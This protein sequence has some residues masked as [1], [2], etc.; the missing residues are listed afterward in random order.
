MR[1][2]KRLRLTWLTIASL[3]LS[4]GVLSACGADGASSTFNT[5]GPVAELQRNLLL[6]VVVIAAGVFVLVEG[7]IVFA[8]LRYR[9]KST[10]SEFPVQTH[11]NSRLELLW[12]AIP[13][14][15]I[16]IIAVPTVQAIW[17]L[18]GQD[19]DMQVDAIGHRWWFEFRY[20]GQGI[21]TANELVIPTGTNIRVNVS[22]ENVNHSFAVP[23]LFGTQDLIPNKNNYIVFSADKPGRYEGQ[24]REFCGL[25]HGKMQ[26]TVLAYPPDEFERWVNEWFTP[27][28]AEVNQMEGLLLFNQNCGTCHTNRLVGSDPYQAEIATQ[29]TRWAGWHGAGGEEGEPNIIPGP[30]LVNF[31]LRGTLAAQYDEPLSRESLL[32][33]IKDPS[34]FK[35]GTY[36]QRY[37]AVYGGGEA[38]LSDAEVQSITD[39]LLAL[40]PEGSTCANNCQAIINAEDEV[41]LR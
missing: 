17:T 16:L 22:S 11:G 12:T 21:V 13:A 30:N 37:A 24:C 7:L 40:V 26:F 1:L 23:N 8:M 28:P 10:D 29:A 18:A 35:I 33:W 25:N 27:P 14:I 3:T 39:Y 31:G 38:N 4:V 41:S 19:Y 5:A 34:E 15:I 6:F 20:P 32:Q 36:M 9:R 2:G